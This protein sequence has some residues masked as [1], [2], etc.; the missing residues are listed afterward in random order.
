MKAKAP[1][2]RPRIS[3]GGIIDAALK[4]LNDVG[5]EQMSTRRLGAALKVQGPALYYHFQDKSELLGHMA[6]A[7]LRQS[8]EGLATEGAWQSWLSKV[9]H[10][11]RGTLLLYRDGPQL[12]AHSSPTEAMRKDVLETLIQP[13]LDAGFSR[14]DADEMIAVLSAFVTGWTIFEQNPAMRELHATRM[15]LDHAFK[16]GVDSLIVGFSREHGVLRSG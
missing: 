12:L 9:A 1:G 5:L 13:L 3:S 10:A 6:V 14:R 16:K 7:M 15:N 4:L 8:L 11:T 2:R